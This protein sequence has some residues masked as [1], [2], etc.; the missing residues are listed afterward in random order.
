MHK[1]GSRA[2]G[3]DQSEGNKPKSLEYSIPTTQG[4]TSSESMR[5]NPWLHMQAVSSKLEYLRGKT[6]CAGRDGIMHV[7]CLT[8]NLLVGIMGIR[9]CVQGWE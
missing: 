7:Y 5:K 3:D 2:T 6:G 9:F 8:V 4:H 1:A